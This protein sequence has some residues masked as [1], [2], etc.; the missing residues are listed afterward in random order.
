ME[1]INKYCNELEE[2][3]VDDL[4]KVKLSYINNKKLK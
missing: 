4:Q 1:D 2:K 3:T